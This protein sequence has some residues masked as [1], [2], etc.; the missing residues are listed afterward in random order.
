MGLFL[1]WRIC[2]RGV[3]FCRGPGHGPGFHVEQGRPAG[4]PSI[5]FNQQTIMKN[6]TRIL[7][8][9]LMFSLGL[10]ARAGD[11]GFIEKFALA[12]DRKEVLKL[13]IPGTRDFYYYH[14]LDAQLRGDGAEV[15]RV[16]AL[17]IK[18]HGRTAR[19]REIQDRQALLDYGN[20]PAATIEHLKRELDLGFNHSRIIEGQKPKH[21]T[22]LDQKL[23]SF[24]A[25]LARA[26][27]SGDLSGVETRGLERLDHDGLNATRLR[28]L[29][30]RLQRPD[31]SGLPRLIIKDLRN[32]YSRG[33]GQHNIHRQLTHDQMD[34]LLQLE[35]GLIDNSNFIH[36]YLTK[37]APSNDIDTRFDLE[38]RG[39]H[40]NRIHQFTQ[41]L[42]AAHNSLKANAMFNLLRFQQSQGKHDRA[43]FMQY[44]RL[45]R[46]VGYI[47]PKYREA[48]LKRPGNADVNLN[49]DYRQVTGLPPIGPDERLVRDFFL[50][51][52]KGD[53][54]FNQYLPVVRDTYLK[55]LFAEA[56]LVNG[57]GDAERWYSMLSSS[58]VQALRERIDLDFSAVNKVFYPAQA[59][60]SLRVNVKNVKQL[61]VRVFEINTFNYYTRN[62]KLIDTAIN[63][64]GLAPTRE[65]VFKYDEAPLRR[66]ER[67]FDFPELK[68]R[69]VY[70]VELI[71]NGRS[72]RALITKGSLRMLRAVGPAGHEFRVLDEDSKPCPAA[73]LWLA[74]QEYKPGE[75]G[76][77]I[78]PFTNR[79]GKQAVVLRH[80][81]FSALSTFHH[82]GETYKLDAG[83]YVDREALVKGAQ[84]Q[85]VVRP[86]L[87]LN[88]QPVSLKVL[89]DVRLVI[90]STDHKGVPTMLE[91]PVPEIPD[92]EAFVHNFT[93]PNKLSQ[94]Q[95]RLKARVENLAAGSKQELSDAATI[96]LNQIDK[97]L[98]VD[99]VHLA[100]VDGGYVLDV[101]G[102][103]GEAKPDRAVVVQL[104]HRDFTGAHSVRL[105]SGPSGR[106][107]LG[108][109]KDIQWINVSH[110]DGTA[111]R[112]EI[113]LPRHGRI[114]QPSVIHAAA[115]DRVQV[116]LPG[117]LDNAAKGATYSLLE[118][119]GNTVTADHV[120]AG[121]FRDGFLEISDL[122][123]G[124]Y[125]LYLKE[126]GEAISL[127]VTDG[128]RRDG[129]VLSSNRILERRVLRPLQISDLMVGRQGAVVRLRNVT[130]FTRLHVIATR[131]E[132]RYEA[133]S[134]LDIGG[135]PAPGMQDVALPRSLY[136]QE[137]D[138][139]E[140]YRYILDRKYAKKYPGN[141]LERPGLLLNP[142][143]IRDTNTGRQDAAAGEEYKR[144]QEALRNPTSDQYYRPASNPAPGS[145]GDFSSLDFLA[146]SSVLLANLKPN[147]E[148]MVEV[149]LDKLNGQQQLLFV[150]V[151]PLNTV[152]R[153]VV[154]QASELARRE[155]RMIQSLDVA[156]AH[157]E[158]KLFT[159]VKK[160]GRLDVQDITTSDVKLYDSLQKAYLLMVTLSN[161]PTLTEFSFVLEWPGLKPEE[162][163]EKYSKYACHELNF[164]LFHKDPEFFNEVIKP[165]LANKNDKT[166]MDEWLLG[167]KLDKYL[168]P[169]AFSQLNDVE[170]ILLARK[171]SA[172]LEKM[173]RYIQD[174]ADLIVPNPERFN[175]LFDTAIKSSALEEKDELGLKDGKRQ[176]LNRFKDRL[177]RATVNR[178]GG[179]DKQDM[180]QQQGQG[181]GQG[182]GAGRGPGFGAPA[183]ANLRPAAAPKPAQPARPGEFSNNANSLKK[184]AEKAEELEQMSKEL[185]LRGRARDLKEGNQQLRLADREDADYARNFDSEAGYFGRRLEE[186]KAV[187]QFFRKL[188]PTKEWAENNYYKLPIAQ[189]NSGLIQVNA[190]WNDYADA[191]A[192]EPFFSGNFIYTTGNFAEMMLALAVLDLPFEAPKHMARTRERSFQLTAGDHLVVCH[193]EIRPTEP[194]KKGPKILLSQ[195]FYRADSRYRH[196]GNERLDNFVDDEFLKQM[197]YGCQVVITNPT[198]SPQKFRLLVQVPEGAIPL[199]GGFYS[200]GRPIRLEPYSTTTF[201]YYFYFPEAG[202][203][204]IYPVQVA[205]TRGHVAAAEDF[206]FDVVNELSRKDKSSW[207]WISQNGTEGDVIKYL[208]DHNLNRLDLNLIAFRLRNP[209]EGGGGR[210][211]YNRL[212]KHLDDRF[213]YH[214]TLWSYSLY[215][216]DGERMGEYLER[217]P[218]AGRVGLYLVSP[219]LTINP[220]ERKWHQHL[221]Y[222]P[223]VNARAHQLGQTRKILNDAFHAQYNDFLQV[224]KY[225]KAINP[226]DLLG[227][228]Y[229]LLLQDRVG[230]ALDAF[231]RVSADQIHEKLQYDYLSAYL[232]LYQGDLKRA[233]Q[234]AKAHA[235]HPV[236]RWRNL[237]AV[238]T[239]QLDEIEGKAGVL[240]DKDNRQQKQDQLAATQ[241]SYEF[242]V[243]D[244][245]VQISYQNVESITVNYYPMDVELLFSRKPFL[246]DDTEHFTYI[247]PNT[248][249]SIELPAKKTAHTFTIPKQFHSSN[250]MVEIVA[251]GI[252]KSQAYYANTLALQMIENYGQ[253]RVTDQASGKPLPKTYVKVYGKL[254]NGQVRFY[255]DGYTDLRGRFDYV[256]LNTG[257]LDNVQQFAILVLN[258]KQGALIR[259]ARPPKQ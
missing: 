204:A 188:P 46:P 170:K 211:F 122:P 234:L 103:N 193:Q 140:E 94:L 137:R 81:S 60:V 151:D 53:A 249:E 85:V 154:L 9:S 63:L 96:S 19:V 61:I 257:E 29:L 99:N 117:M 48:L 116:A 187:R 3:E 100:R 172:E 166:F 20:N 55:A 209:N 167:H 235:Q 93:V 127:R 77:I 191:P 68:E 190:F 89:E 230:E 44:L 47:N 79:P 229:Y 232:A 12:K 121:S 252:R 52:F 92:G 49:A 90:L 14:A 258:E 214:H 141:M 17:W 45:P 208:R 171:G 226:G 164:F 27:R 114:A 156:K 28:H 206:S 129:H 200:E 134:A 175:R 202:K 248:V 198:S 146:H 10:V 82:R 107:R 179:K 91:V 76:A 87:R 130:P 31:V 98:K 132:P 84:A 250:V 149:G 176:A 4:D 203:Y 67:K 184:A 21:P 195:N 143:A 189:Q 244:R 34:E 86:V 7:S 197:A 108:A 242:K 69:G 133:Y 126:T 66:V 233:R 161:N 118:M 37:L 147:K 71:G 196:V 227:V 212:M 256:S 124:D 253:V 33:F 16:V 183:D 36:A 155:N 54:D 42:S 131:F 213:T 120:K 247:V 70:V 2:G 216:R 222:K 218:M 43:L 113:A 50:H 25:F 135:V 23:I 169:F 168:E 24:E 128:E 192:D 219:L 231:G 62:L 181:Q 152:T 215:H 245:Q 51:F 58:Q 251:N 64:D 144:L 158:Q 236:D 88:G 238:V 35:P 104:K 8:L 40:L 1:Q 237:F 225:H 150:A 112:W 101:L 163:Q 106:V 160:G 39:K 177:E 243:E 162:K 194:Q 83:L 74:G 145:L 254:A 110:Y 228:T 78:V 255:K 185:Q 153:P 182:E 13:L 173:R 30:S 102:K 224:L 159:V 205:S 26:F 111:Y 157:S 174:K 65:Q 95:F 240:V 97:T 148:G 220:V 138:I 259:E 57:V 142:W 115:G 241:A 207:A 75:D 217:S 22:A 5:H 210:D 72:S 221:E 180:A 105:K 15:R 119:R 223:L 186:R 59:P 239:S 80:G 123:A 109:L 178:A 246:K 32:K 6:T 41:R 73:T 11:I 136:V 125:R 139:G 56:K 201:D 199:Q 18:R 165:Y 38:E